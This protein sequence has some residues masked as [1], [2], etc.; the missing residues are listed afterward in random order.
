VRS[1]PFSSK[2]PDTYDRCGCLGV[3]SYARCVIDTSL[4]ILALL[5]GKGR[6]RVGGR[7]SRQRLAGSIM[8]P[9]TLYSMIV[10]VVGQF[11]LKI[12]ISTTINSGFGDERIA[13]LLVFMTADVAFRIWNLFEDVPE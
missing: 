9:A 3:D 1:L 8:L 12:P 6:H 11:A 5:L 2:P 13:W 4:V 7:V 10:G